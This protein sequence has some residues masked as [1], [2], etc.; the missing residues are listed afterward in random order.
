MKFAFF[1]YLMLFPIPNS[2]L[3]FT[4]KLFTTKTRTLSL[5]GHLP[6]Y[7]LY[8]LWPSFNLYLSLTISHYHTFLKFE[9][10][11]LLICIFL[12]AYIHVYSHKIS[13]HLV[14]LCFFLLEFDCSKFSMMVAL[15]K[16]WMRFG[17]IETL[18]YLVWLHIFCLLYFV[19]FLGL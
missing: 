7:P 18:K 13:S 2:H 1:N 15:L 17:C 16:F 10:Y 5:L 12:H 6:I 3:P 8:I 11:N 9:Y 14:C 19:S 4:F